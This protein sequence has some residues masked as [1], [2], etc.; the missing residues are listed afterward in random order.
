MNNLAEEKKKQQA[1]LAALARGWSILPVDI[2]KKPHKV[3]IETGHLKKN[4]TL[5]KPSWQKLQTTR[6]HAEEVLIWAKDKTVTGFAVV[7]GL[8]SQIFVLDFDGEQGIQLMRKLKLKPH[9]QTGSGGFHVYVRHPGWKITTF[10]SKSKK[11]ITTEW[12]G[13]DLRGDGGYAVMP[14]ARNVQGEYQALR[15][16]EDLE[17][18]ENLPKALQELL[19]PIEKVKPTQTSSNADLSR[20]DP[21]ERLVAQM[22]R[23]A[24][25]MSRGE[26][27]N[28]SGFWL[29]CQL[30]DQ[31]LSLNEAEL[32]LTQFVNSVDSVNTKGYLENYSLQEARSSLHSAFSVQ[33][34][35]PWDIK[36]D[37]TKNLEISTYSLEI[38]PEKKDFG[39]KNYLAEEFLEDLK[40]RQKILRFTSSFDFLDR[41]LGGGY[42]DGFHILGGATGVGKTALALQIATTNANKER[43]VLYLTY[44][45]SKFE[46]WGRILQTAGLDLQQLRSGNPD[47]LNQIGYKN[48]QEKVSPY[49]KILEGFQDSDLNKLIN[50]LKSFKDET[51]QMPLIILDYLQ[52][53]PTK[54]TTDKRLQIDELVGRLQV[55]LARQHK[56]TILAISS[57]SRGHYGE[58]LGR[59]LEERLG[60]WKESGGIE[61]TAYTATLVYPLSVKQMRDLKLEPSPALGT[62]A[63]QS[64]GVWRYVV[65]DLVKNRE[66]ETD[67]QMVLKWYPSK[68]CFEFVK[69]INSEVFSVSSRKNTST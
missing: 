69:H 48:I 65:L 34:R 52:R 67:V 40:E 51:G 53:V 16:F 36:M 17:R 62:P 19:K 45:Q 59:S 58:L 68:G 2:H 61:Y 37:H 47:L 8:I 57:L 1:A 20:L 23:R 43:P 66:G 32:V 14:P 28:N 60:V 9:V 29:A 33:A 30:R 42:Y 38:L 41:Y 22:L 15:S 35:Q 21:S 27:R 4:E 55:E 39:D 64:L 24:L 54:P 49:L 26:G 7:T 12:N 3:L 31:G 25:E 18:F 6:P 11:K 13:L 10:N 5:L 63:A 56:A 50:I 46:L 44:E